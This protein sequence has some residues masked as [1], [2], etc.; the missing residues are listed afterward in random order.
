MY[1]LPAMALML[2]AN[3]APADFVRAESV[4]LISCVEKAMGTWS[5]DV[6]YSDIALDFLQEIDQAQPVFSLIAALEKYR[7][8]Y[9]DNDQGT[10]IIV[11]AILVAAAGDNDLTG[12]PPNVTKLVDEVRRVVYP[13]ISVL[14]A[15]A[16]QRVRENS[17]VRELWS[18]GGTCALQ[19]W[20]AGLQ[21][22][23]KRLR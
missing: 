8:T 12:I 18:E 1:C 3:T 21:V 6:W 4:T 13:N 2:I 20:E 7:S 19:N 10:Q 22:V 23:E 16:I 17:E 11:S 5:D 14:A 9:I 15:D